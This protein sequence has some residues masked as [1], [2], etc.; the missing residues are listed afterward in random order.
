MRLERPLCSLKSQRRMLQ[1][2]AHFHEKDSMKY[3]LAALALSLATIAAFSQ[4]APRVQFTKDEL[5]SQ[6]TGMC[7]NPDGS[8]P[9]PVPPEKRPALEAYC[10]CVRASIDRIPESR[11]QQAA[12]ETFREYAQYRNDPAGFIP[13]AEY[14]LVRLSKACI[15]K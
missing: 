1:I 4:E 5:M 11:L 3:L 9:R 14:S 8:Y 13:S 2:T 15:K 6:V 12:E 7:Q 10:S